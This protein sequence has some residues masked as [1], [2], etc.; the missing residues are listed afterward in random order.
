M[1]RVLIDTNC[2]VAYAISVHE[3]HAATF[4]DVERRRNSAHELLVASHSLIEAYSVLTRMPPPYRLT[5]ADALAAIDATWGK[6]ETVALTAAELWRALRT[7]AKAEIGGGR[8]YDAVI[9]ES[10]RKGKATEILTWNTRHFDGL[11]IAA[12][13]PR[14]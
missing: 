6:T 13:A 9:A 10:A 11:G 1:M 3:F 7:S 12:V 5:P 14:T 2:L 8:I 4:A